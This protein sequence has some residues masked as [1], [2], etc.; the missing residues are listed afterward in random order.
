MPWTSPNADIAIIVTMV[1][2]AGRT[3][4][5]RP[6]AEAFDPVPAADLRL[7][8]VDGVDGLIHD[9]GSD[10]ANVV[11]TFARIWTTLATGVIRSKDGAASWA[12]DRLP[13]A[14]RPVMAKAREVYLGR[15][16]D[17]WIDMADEAAACVD[18]MRE[19]I[20]DLARR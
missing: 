12:L 16:S 3:V 20:V 8:L 9:L 2:A 11:L 10:T 19:R 15:S 14:H 13:L 1:L 7:A 5:G 6:A 18:A 17:H 4:L